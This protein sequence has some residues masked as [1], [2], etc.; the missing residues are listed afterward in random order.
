MEKNPTQPTLTERLKVADRSRYFWRK[1]L[2]DAHVTAYLDSGVAPCPFEDPKKALKI[3][4]LLPAWAMK[5]QLI[6]FAFCL[7]KNHL[8]LLLRVEGQD[9][10]T[11]L[12][13]FL[14]SLAKSLK[15]SLS[16]LNY[17]SKK[18]TSQKQFRFHLHAITENPGEELLIFNAM[19]NIGPTLKTTLKK[20]SRFKEASTAV[21]GDERQKNFYSKE[22]LPIYQEGEACYFLTIYHE[23]TLPQTLLEEWREE[24]SDYGK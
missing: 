17:Q 24:I 7:S 20:E 15:I 10:E 6:P 13:E 5:Q 14:K 4:E 9:F 12:R 11:S 1:N 22:K 8:H 16:A 23:E 18:I 21:C 2:L 19:Q 3:A